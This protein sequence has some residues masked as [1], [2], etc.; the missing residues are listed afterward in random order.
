MLDAFAER[1]GLP[2]PVTYGEA[3]DRVARSGEP[4]MARDYTRAVLAL[5]RD[6]RVQGRE[7]TRTKGGPPSG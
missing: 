3:L 7:L 5:R 1:L 2:A 4:A 6:E